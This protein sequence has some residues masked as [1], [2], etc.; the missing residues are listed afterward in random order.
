MDEIQEM[1]SRYIWEKL[2]K[3]EDGYPIIDYKNEE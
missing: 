3:D 2:E 1:L